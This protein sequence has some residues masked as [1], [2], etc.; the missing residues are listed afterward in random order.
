MP[1][2]RTCFVLVLTCLFI[3]AGCLNPS[4]S[5]P[6]GVVTTLPTNEPTPLTT[7]VTAPPSPSPTPYETIPV[8]YSNPVYPVYTPTAYVTPYQTRYVPYRQPTYSPNQMPGYS[9][10][11]QTGYIPSRST[12]YRP[13]GLLPG[14]TSSQYAVPEP[15]NP[16]DLVFQHYSDQNFGIDYPT[17][18]KVSRSGF[19]ELTSASGRVSFTAEVSDFLP[20]L[21][22]NFR[23]NP[24]ISAVQNILSHEFPAYD[25]HNLISNY[26]STTIRGIPATIYSVNVPDGSEA[27]TRYIMVTLHHAYWFTFSSDP[28]TF[29]QV[30]PLRDYMFNTLTIADQA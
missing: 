25:P 9:P 12:G 19:V 6:G 22:G 3:T 8:T 2:F 21:A 1:G 14:Y 18:W 23:L 30:G 13:P 26:Q 5:S 7:I 24:D 29:N 15:S 11:Q 20:G 27:Y 10:Y 16:A 4:G 28:A 17:T